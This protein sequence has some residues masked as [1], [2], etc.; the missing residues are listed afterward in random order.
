MRIL[1]ET[2]SL[3]TCENPMFE[4]LQE[5]LRHRNP[6]FVCEAAGNKPEAGEH[7]A[8]IDHEVTPG[9]DA[10]ALAELRKQVGDLSHLLAF[11]ERYGSV[12]LFRDSIEQKW[13]GRESAYYL[14]PPDEWVELR[15]QA[16]SWFDDLDEDDQETLPDWITEYVVVG[17]IPESGNYFLVPLVG[18][19][20]GKV[21]MFDH[22]GYLFSECG[23]NFEEFV[24]AL[25]SVDA[26]HLDRMGE[27][28]RYSDGVTSYQWMPKTYLH[29]S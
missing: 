3:G 1:R 18:E 2:D 7:I 14:A 27:H 23:S 22:D 17:E 10:N 11:Y 24:N 16:E 8:H 29:E 25:A 12:R 15:D 4:Q 9:L 26:E 28:T 21:Y 20:R 13:T 19:D 6:R 5:I